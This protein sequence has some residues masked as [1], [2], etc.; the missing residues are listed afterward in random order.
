[1]SIFPPNRPSNAAILR[2]FDHYGYPHPSP[3]KSKV[4]ALRRAEEPGE[5]NDLIGIMGG[6]LSLWFKGTTDPGRRPMK[7]GRGV[8][9][10]GVAR[11]APGFYHDVWGWGWHKGNR[12]HPCLRQKNPVPFERYR[13]NKWNLH[14]PDVRGFNLHRSRWSGTPEHVGHY[15]HGCIVI[16]DRLEHWE[17]LQTLGYPDPPFT[18]QQESSRVDLVLIDWSD[19]I[20]NGDTNGS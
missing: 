4:V 3:A 17:F 15:S 16:P 19:Y 12:K 7:G 2:A 5:W 11:I 18:P 9:H 8:H 6:G 10:A 13:H 14:A 20:R 1:M